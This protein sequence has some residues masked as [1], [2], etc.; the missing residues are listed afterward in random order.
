[1]MYNS[2]SNYQTSS[3][4]GSIYTLKKSYANITYENIRTFSGYVARHKIYR[5]SL[6]SNADY[7]IIADAPLEIN[8][9]LSDRITQ[10]KYY[11]H[12]GKFYNDEHIGKY[13]F[14]SSNNI[15][16]T[17]SPYQAVNSMFMS[18]PSVSALSGS[19]Y[20]IV[21]NHSVTTNRNAIYVPFD[22]NQYLA[23]SGSS[24]DSNF[25]AL[26]S[27]VQY[28]IEISAVILKDLSK[29]AELS[30]YFTSSISNA[31]KESTYNSK[32]GIKIANII[33][34]Q[35]SSTVNINNF[36]TFYTPKSDLYGTLVIVPYLCQTYIKNISFRIY[37]DD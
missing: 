31:K 1:M 19:D 17:H 10:N 25:M 36:I 14:T 27:N 37:G 18:S 9:I 5:K 35:N 12:L 4:S 2:S 29:T 26:K 21:K 20:L 16:L 8:E 11:Q 28:I 22:M 34:N 15:S 3:I 24:Y 33:T 6:I 23:E 13:W 30:F 32:F 7:S